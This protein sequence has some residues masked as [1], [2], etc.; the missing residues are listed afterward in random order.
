MRAWLFVAL[1]MISGCGDDGPPVQE[2]RTWQLVGEGRPSSLLSVWSSSIND[3]WLVGG[4]EGLGLGPTVF[5]FDGT[6][7]TKRDTGLVNVDLWT[8]FGFANGDVFLGGSNGTLLRHRN[9]AFEKLTTPATDIVFGLWGNSADDVWAVGGQTASRPFVWRLQGSAFVAQTGIPAGLTGAV[10]KVTGRAADDV[11]ISG[12]QGFVLHWDGQ[13]LGSEKVGAN[14]ESLFSIGCGAARCITAG[15]NGSNGVLYENVGQG[16]TSRVPTQD[17]PIWRGITPVG[18]PPYV[19]GMFG[20][21]LERDGETWKIDPHGLTTEALH[22]TWLDADGNLFAVGGK[23]DRA[24][25]LD[26]VVI[27]NGTAELPALP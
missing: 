10:W 19:V 6:A 5:H 20:A 25:T 16:W 7:W 15:S 9:G 4:R 23:F 2:E 11:W 26:G 1:W 17:G 22:A 12:S 18:D 14:S 24:Q 3:V 21:V 13:T 27:Y 8:V